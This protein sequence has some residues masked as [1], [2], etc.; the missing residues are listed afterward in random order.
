MHL[1]SCSQR[2]ERGGQAF[3]R[4]PSRP[5]GLQRSVE[6]SLSSSTASKH[7]PQPGTLRKSR[8]WSRK[9]AFASVRVKTVLSQVLEKAQNQC[10]ARGVL[11]L[12]LVA[13]ANSWAVP[14]KRQHGDRE[15]ADTIGGSTPTLT[16]SI[17]VAPGAIY[18]APWG[19]E[20]TERH[21]DGR[22]IDAAERKTSTSEEGVLWPE[23]SRPRLDARRDGSA[24]CVFI[25]TLCTQ[26]PHAGRFISLERNS[27]TFEFVTTLGQPRA[28]HGHDGLTCS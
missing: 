26:V 11:V 20:R 16:G 6:Q 25:Q 2:L 21:D 22:V 23:Q 4:P 19:R 27:P 17:R 12:L 1:S 8:L 3:E 24:P 10:T 15:N 13:G 14:Q 18:F 28:R 7:C 5:P 9:P